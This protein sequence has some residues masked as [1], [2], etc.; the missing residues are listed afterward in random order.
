M[1]RKEDDSL[2]QDVTRQGSLGDVQSKAKQSLGDQSTFGD[3]GS[4]ASDVSGLD[5]AFD[6]DMEVVD[7]SSRYEIEGVLG[8]GGMGEVLRAR[9]KRLDRP[10][11]IKRIKSQIARSQQAVGRFLTEAQSVAK[12]NYFNI[13][14]IH[15]YG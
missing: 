14:Q 15:D 4:S 7:L 13:V 11:A 3:T 6:S 8:K 5:D 2:G 9:D 12:L 1:P 10:V